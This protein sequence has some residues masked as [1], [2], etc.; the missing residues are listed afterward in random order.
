M[1]GI[2]L[3]TQTKTKSLR[4][5]YL[6]FLN[7]EFGR[8]ILVYLN[9][10]HRQGHIKTLQYHAL[11]QQRPKQRVT[12]RNQSAVINSLNPSLSQKNSKEC[13]SQE[14]QLK[15]WKINFS[16]RRNPVVQRVDVQ[17]EMKNW[18]FTNDSAYSGQFLQ[19]KALRLIN[20]Q[21]GCVSNTFSR[22]YLS[23]VSA[24]REHQRCANTHNCLR[25]IR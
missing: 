6:K 20:P 12:D 21:F 24:S 2:F 25:P 3:T 1:R 13:G 15:R 17:I 19:K 7:R 4:Q 5:L 14:H 23:L 11:E 9:S 18:Y 16:I 8:Y 10:H 22:I